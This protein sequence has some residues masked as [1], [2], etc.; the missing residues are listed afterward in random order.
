M[1]VRNDITIDWESSPRII[2]VADPSTELT[3]QDL[4]DTIR[5][6]EQSPEGLDRLKL[7]DSAGKEDLGS[8]V[9]VGIT[10]TL[11][12]SQVAFE[13]R[14]SPT[15]IQCKVSGGNLVAVD[16]NGDSISPIKETAYTQVTLAQSTSASIATA[17]Q[18]DIAAI[19]GRATLTFLNNL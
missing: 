10:A 2:T 13:D 6:I 15:Y 12:N 9:K 3:I 1:S 16:G 7:I 17:I 11:Q 14:P 18:Q 5:S 8:G 4:H 19:K